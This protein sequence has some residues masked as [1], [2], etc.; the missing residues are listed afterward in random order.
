MSGQQPKY[1]AVADGRDTGVYNNWNDAKAA[2]NGHPGNIH[3]S[4]R[5][6]GEARDF[7]TSGGAPSKAEW[8]ESRGGYSS[9]GYKPKK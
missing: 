3:Q 1:Y 8:A 6:A 5:D 9:N 7:V 4:F 2:T